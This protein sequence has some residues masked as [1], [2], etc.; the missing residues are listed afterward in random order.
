MEVYKYKVYYYV[1]LKKF[2]NLRFLCDIFNEV[3]K[4]NNNKIY[5]ENGISVYNVLKMINKRGL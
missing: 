2:D 5:L 4:G 1:M 3:D